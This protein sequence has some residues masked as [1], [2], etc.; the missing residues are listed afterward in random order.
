VACVRILIVDD[1]ASWR[2]CAALLLQFEPDLQV[3]CQAADG[4]EAVE[5]S[6]ALQPDLILLD[7]GLPNLN[8][9]EAARQ[10]G[11]VAPGSKILFVSENC[12]QELTRVAL[13]TGALGY[14]L[15]SDAATELLPAVRAVLAGQQFVSPT[16]AG[17][18]SSDSGRT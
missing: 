11:K 14:L 15:K 5:K 17:T 12:C 7:I 8:G 10:I 3:I 13:G 18:Q 1:Y 4:L 6:A 16:I 2:Q 9:L